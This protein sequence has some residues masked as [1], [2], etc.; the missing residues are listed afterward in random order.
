M[1][2]IIRSSRLSVLGLGLPVATVALML[3]SCRVQPAA[4]DAR[5]PAAKVNVAAA[6]RRTLVS[7]IELPGSLRPAVTADVTAPFE[8]RVTSMLAREGDRVRAGSVLATVSPAV[9]EEIVN[10]AR[11]ELER[12]RRAGEDTMTA[13]EQFDFAVNAYREAPVVSAID[14]VVARRLVDPGEMVSVRQRLYEVQSARRFHVEVEVSELHL[15][16]LRKGIEVRVTLDA[17]PESVLEGVVRRIHPFVAEQTRT[18]TVEI[19]LLS[20]PAGVQAGMFAR[21]ALPVGRAADAVVVPERALLTAPDGSP[22]IFV[23]ADSTA[24]RRRVTVG[25]ESADG[26]EIKSG[27]AEGGMVVV[28]GQEALKDGQRVIVV[29]GEKGPT[30]PA[31]P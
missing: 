15:S 3:F 27:L 13:R 24:S 1:T 11:F 16:A 29:E 14:G 7:T 6:H 23:V 5:Q 20:A 31:R 21:V 10:A 17:L 19:D 9:R 28:A 25:I 4:A 2:A 8:G 12:R 18:S 30:P 22:F 26:V